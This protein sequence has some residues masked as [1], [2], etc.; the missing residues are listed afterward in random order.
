MGSPL[1]LLASNSP[2]RQQMLSWTSWDFIIRPVN[3]DESPRPGEIASDYVLRMAESK[4]RAAASQ[5][6]QAGEIVLA[7]DTTVVDGEK[8]LG[9]PS[10]RHEAAQMLSELRG[11]THQVYSAI[12][13]YLPEQE[14]LITDLCVS[15]VP[16]RSYSDSEIETYIDSGDPF[17]KAGAYAIQNRS[18]RPVINF[19]HCYASVMG[20]PL[21]HLVRTLRGAG[22]QTVLDV[23]VACQE[24]LQYACPVSDL[25]LKGKDPS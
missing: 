7:A 20:L 16:M 17:D 13:I 25:I 12:A 21:C 18:F 4:A 24:N 15:P 5:G 2:R 10:D 22:I 9:K 6:V 8:L 11:R 19:S 3:V 14:R 23:A 1:I